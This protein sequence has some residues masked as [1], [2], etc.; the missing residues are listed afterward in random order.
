MESN[1]AVFKRW[2]M[3]DAPR[4]YIV[5]A[6]LIGTFVSILFLGTTDLIA[7]ADPNPVLFLFSSLIAG[8]LTLISIISCLGNSVVVRKPRRHLDVR[9]II[10]CLVPL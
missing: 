3:M 10:A 9:S 8:N 6:I 1:D 4:I 7:V 2:V 5:T